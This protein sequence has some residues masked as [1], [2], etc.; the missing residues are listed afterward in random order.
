MAIT[1][2]QF[3]QKSYRNILIPGFNIGDEPIEIRVRTLSLMNM[4]SRKSIP[5]PLMP[6][7]NK[8]FKLGGKVTEEEAEKIAVD[9]IDEMTEFLGFI[10]DKAMIEPTYDEIGEY[11]TQEQVM[12]VF[13]STQ[14]T[15]NN[16]TPFRNE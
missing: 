4:I 16:L 1:A 2:E 6:A 10:C 12:A 5:N 7:V 3:I 14:G 9:N 11:M 13:S 8:L 15:V